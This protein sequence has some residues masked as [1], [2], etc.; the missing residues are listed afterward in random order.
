MIVSIPSSDSPRAAP[1]TVPQAIVHPLAQGWSLEGANASRL[2]RLETDRVT[3]RHPAVF[4]R[5]DAQLSGEWDLLP[6][7]EQQAQQVPNTSE[8]QAEGWCRFCT[9][10][11]RQS[12][13]SSDATPYK[14]TTTSIPP[15]SSF[16]R[17]DRDYRH[18][19]TRHIG[20]GSK[21]KRIGSHLQHIELPRHI[22]RFDPHSI[23]RSQRECLS[24]SSAES[25]RRQY[26][27]EK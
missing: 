3:E 24:R 17:C 18:T 22:L 15:L 13:C 4:A 21:D 12:E 8:G 25:Q 7:V 19:H 10:L 27:S 5:E 1:Y 11:A 14:E 6:V 9:V 16:K 23:T 26:C 20:I 2:D